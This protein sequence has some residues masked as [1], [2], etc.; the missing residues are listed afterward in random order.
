M[1]E[2]ELITQLRNVVSDK[3]GEI[4]HFEFHK[5][6]SKIIQSD[7]IS[8]LKEFLD[9]FLNNSNENFFDSHL[10]NIVLS[11]YEKH[12]DKRQASEIAKKIIIQSQK[13]SKKQTSF[14][15]AS[16]L[17][18]CRKLE[19]YEK[20]ELLFIE[21][22]D[23]LQTSKFAVLYELTFYYSSKNNIEAIDAVI[24]RIL[25]ISKGKD[26]IIKTVSS[27]CLKYGLYEKYQKFLIPQ[28]K[29]I[30]KRAETEE[31]TELKL[32]GEIEEE[33]YQKVF[34]S[35]AI[36]DLT[37]GIAHE[38]GQP[39]TN[40]RYTIQLYSRI[41]ENQKSENINSDIIKKIFDDIL[42]QTERI[43]R[44][45]NRL[46]VAT[47]AKITITNF[48][49][50]ETLEKIF[51]QEIARLESNNITYEF[52][53]IDNVDLFV[54]FDYTQFTQIIS[55]LLNNSIDS[56]I[57]KS[58]ENKSYSGR[59]WVTVKKIGDKFSI[60]FADNGKGINPK[61]YDRLFN[62]YFTT[63]PPDK[64]QGLGLYI[65]SNLLKMNS[66]SISIDRRSKKGAKFIIIIPLK[67]DI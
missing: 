58:N 2:L 23:L 55:N 67:R 25:S 34:K 59:I 5:V 30:L 42:L 63:K 61:N 27:L 53:S 22:P 47:S 44:L 32:I 65:V 21:H 13:N 37:K 10:A 39:V 1:K 33:E 64:G 45:V 29:N 7:K 38:F 4:N 24:N 66:S 52:K 19:N 26:P 9:N 51:K 8:E 18:I 49:L 41:F 43:G 35:A 15:L 6:I 3:N 20:I 16:L 50:L 48:N 36:A 31:E 60:W 28:K 46:S 57:E 56:I 62:P 11:I 54:Q 17:R 40:I 12:L 14:A